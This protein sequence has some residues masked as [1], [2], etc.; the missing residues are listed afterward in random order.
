[1]MALDA[2]PGQHANQ[3]QWDGYSAEREEILAPVPFEGGEEPRRA[4]RRHPHLHR[5]QPD[6][7]RRGLG[8]PDRSRVGRRLGDVIR[9]AGGAR[10]FAGDPGGA[11]PGVGSAHHLRRLRASG[12]LRGH[13]RKRTRS[14]AS[15]GP[16]IPSPRRPRHPPWPSS[17]SRPVP[18]A[19]AGLG[20]RLGYP[21]S[22]RSVAVRDFVREPT[23]GREADHDVQR[24][25]EV[26]G[27]RRPR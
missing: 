7:D 10:Y 12:V 26:Q 2:A 19:A 27:G 15:S 4:E 6:D 3:D 16:R 17:R 9:P 23:C 25:R 20:P 14:S 24:H 11:A 13:G 22:L 1:M 8:D 5:R 18:D 21:R